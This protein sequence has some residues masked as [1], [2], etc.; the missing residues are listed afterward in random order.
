MLLNARKQ[1]L[2]VEIGIL[3]NL[4]QMP[5]EGLRSRSALVDQL[6]KRLLKKFNLKE[7]ELEDPVI[8][9]L[10]HANIHLENKLKVYVTLDGH[11]NNKKSVGATDGDVKGDVKLRSRLQKELF[12][13]LN[14]S[15]IDLVEGEDNE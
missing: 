12:K 10:K 11:I 2:T 1:D 6:T 8:E 5:D 14:V 7:K 15:A 13:V 9:E 4:M 3:S